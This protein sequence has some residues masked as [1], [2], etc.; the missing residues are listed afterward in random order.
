LVQSNHS[1]EI[2]IVGGAWCIDFVCKGRRS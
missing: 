1:I 2:D